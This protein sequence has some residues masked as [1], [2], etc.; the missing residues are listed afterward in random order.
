MDIV[1]PNSIPVEWMGLEISSEGKTVFLAGSIEMGAA[2][3]WQSEVESRLS[4]FDGTILNPR[5]DDWDSSWEQTTIKEQFNYQ[6]SWELNHLDKCDIIFMYFAPNTKSPISLLELGLYANSGKMIVCCPKE[7]WRH[8][9]VSI[10]CTR[11]NIPLFDNLDDTIGALM[12]K[13]N[14]E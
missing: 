11:Y 2:V 12:V 14:K 7:F 1:K 4:D 8:G 3:D 10:V 5:R 13:L 9:N 6:V